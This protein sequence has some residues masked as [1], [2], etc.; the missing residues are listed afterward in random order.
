MRFGLRSTSPPPGT[1]GALG[2][3]G[4]RKAYL[5]QVSGILKSP[6][7][8][9]PSQLAHT[10]NPIHT[11]GPTAATTSRK[12]QMLDLFCGTGS[13]GVVY[14]LLGYEVT[15]MDLDP[16]WHFQ[17]DVMTWRYWEDLQPGQYNVVVAAVPCTEYSRDLT[18]ICRRPTA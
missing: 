18:G 15:T 11:G 14:R 2:A 16:K 9:T 12:P 6:T 3:E 13:A 17:V 7:S 1:R 5:G 4:V 10:P 8:T